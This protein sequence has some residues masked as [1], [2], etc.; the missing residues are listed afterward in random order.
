MKLVT[1][2][3]KTGKGR[4]FEDIIASF[5][6]ANTVKTASADA[7]K[8]A[9]TVAVATEEE[10]VKEA[11]GIDNFGDKRAE[12]FGKKKDEDD[13]KKDDDKK[14]DDK[15]DDDKKEAEIEVEI[16]KEAEIEVEIR[17]AGEGAEESEAEDKV[18]V[19]S[20]CTCCDDKCGECEDCK[21]CEGCDGEDCKGCEGCDGEDCKGCKSC[22]A[23]SSNEKTKIADGPRFQ[24]IANL[25]DKSKTWLVE[26]WSKLY[27]REYAEAMTADK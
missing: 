2:S 10:E 24:K 4:S 17:I 19:A 13:D 6:K 8:T 22:M 7:V 25:D 9:E 27:P 5:S 3:I 23:A 12:P 20:K 16:R 15:E 1:H 26:Y 18:K 14:D 21:G 11:A